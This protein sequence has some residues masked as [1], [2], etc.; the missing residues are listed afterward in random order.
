MT[1]LPT[2][3]LFK[4]AQSA[5]DELVAL[6]KWGCKKAIVINRFGTP[7]ID[8]FIENIQFDELDEYYVEQQFNEFVVILNPLRRWDPEFDEEANR[9]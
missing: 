6:K 3:D 1:L 7:Y 4:N 5:A 8:V 9:Y 2:E